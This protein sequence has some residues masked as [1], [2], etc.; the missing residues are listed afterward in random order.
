MKIRTRFSPSPT[1]IIHLGN[2]RTAL[3]SALFAAKHQ[4]SFILRIEDTDTTRSLDHYVDL[5]QED[6]HWLGIDWQEGPGVHGDF[7]PYWQSQRQNIYNK[8]FE[9]LEEKNLI[10]PC[11]CTDQELAVSRKLQLSRGH[12]PR[13]AGT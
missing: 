8:Y 3:F 13:Y 7:G 11:F 2:A 12:A 4:G 9:I 5:L 6:L 1:G 10:Y